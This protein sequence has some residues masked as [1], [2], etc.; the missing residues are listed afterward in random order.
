MNDLGARIEAARARLREAR[1]FRAEGRVVRVAGLAVESQGPPAAVGEA[2][3]LLYPDGK[4]AA[5]GEV[6]G[7]H[8]HRVFSM[9]TDRLHGLSVGARVVALGARPRVPVGE[10][11]LG[12]VLDADGRPLDGKPAPHAP[13]SRALEAEAPRALRRRR[14]REPFVTGVR[15]V[16]AFLTLGR[17]QRV[18]IFAGSGV[19]K[20]TLLGM[21][22]RH[23]RADVAVVALVGERGREVRDFI[24]GELGAR[25]L[26]HSVVLVATSDEPALRRIRAAHTAMA[27]AEYFR[28]QG[29]HVVFLMDSLT[30]VAM[31][32]REVGLSLGEPPSSKG[33]PPSVF[34][35]LAR[36][37][38]RAGAVEGGGAITGIYAVYVEGDDLADP[39]ADAARSLLDGHL[40]LSRDLASRG[41]YPAVDVLASISRLMPRVVGQDHARAAETARRW[42]A[43]YRAAED[44]V[45]LGAYKEGTDPDVDRALRARAAMERLLR[46]GAEDGASFEETLERLS[47][48]LA[49]GEG[50]KA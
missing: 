8:G 26:E 37:V 4:L 50:G 9:P 11:L 30:R 3:L 44:L 20:S 23:A 45:L 48:L 25:G 28:D 32:Q 12:R 42:L 15:A 14:I 16:D 21:I 5:R 29:R 18:G 34:S 33:Y 7:F 41:H 38:E 19:G 35:L 24:E 47:E 43:A 40:V 27:V 1:L 46:Q 13:D 22:A 17:G 39:I 31:A 6:V 10:A 49:A 36:L 2:C